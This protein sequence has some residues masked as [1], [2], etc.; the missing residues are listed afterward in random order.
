MYDLAIL[1]GNVVSSGSVAVAD[2]LIKDGVVAQVLPADE[3]GGAGRGGVRAQREV[4]ACGMLVMPGVIDPHVHFELRSRGTVTADDFASG[5]RCAAAGGVT[6]VIDY[7]DHLPG[8]TLSQ[9]AA[10]RLSE[11]RPQ[12]AVDYAVHQNCIRLA[13]DIGDQ[14]AELR[15]A[16]IG[17]VKVFTTYKDAGYMLEGGDLEAL[18]CEA[19]RHGVLVTV[20][21]EDDD[22]IEQARRRLEA[23][24][25]VSPA[26]HGESRPAQAEE[27]AARQVIAAAKA[28]DAP[29]YLVHVS[30]RGAMEAIAEARRQGQQ[31]LAETCPHYLLLDE[32]RY[33]GA[34]ARLFIMSPPLRTQADHKALWAA[35]AAGHIDTF[36]TDHCAFT[37]EQKELGRSCFDTLPGIPGVQTL[38]PLVYTYG[39][40]AGIITVEQM[41]EMMCANPARLFGLSH[42]KGRIAPGLDA[43]IVILDGAARRRLRGA[44]LLSKAGYTPYEGMEVSCEVREV[45]LRG[46]LVAAHGRFCGACGAGEFVSASA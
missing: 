32:G 20:H 46:S 19:K 27:Q 43:D 11:I 38:L 10:A 40:T 12:A 36:S 14:L 16:G 21:A 42:R 41:A 25:R 45:Y 15:R 8:M 2:I 35:A 17:S 7:A 28:A 39:V 34:D 30:T 23:A 29:V 37:P 13:R 26:Y 22:L 18:L 44:Q 4:D 3:R 5:T 6:T 24:G 33:S 1:G 9:C 31:V